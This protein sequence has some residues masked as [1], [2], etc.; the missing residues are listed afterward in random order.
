MDANTFPAGTA[1]VTALVTKGPIE[2]VA[3]ALEVPSVWFVF[4]VNTTLSVLLG[5]ANVQ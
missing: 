5:F 1:T 2:S 3:A 4:Q